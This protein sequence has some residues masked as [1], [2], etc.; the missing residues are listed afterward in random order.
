MKI[1]KVDKQQQQQQCGPRKGFVCPV[2]SSLGDWSRN[3]GCNS[4]SQ[5]VKKDLF[6]TR[7]GLTDLTG[8]G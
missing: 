7:T 5:E 2:S 3:A 8:V 1:K 4:T 6:Y